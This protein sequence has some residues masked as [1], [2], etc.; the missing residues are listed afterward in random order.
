MR[1]PKY[2]KTALCRLAD[3]GF[4]ACLVGGCVR[5]FLMGIP[6][7]DFDITTSALP[8]QIC[9]IFAGYK[10]ATRGIIHGTVTVIFEGYP[11][12]ITSF[13][14]ESAYSDRR[15]PDSVLFGVSLKEDLMRRDFT[16]NAIAYRTQDGIYDP[17]GGAAD[18]KAKQ[19]RCVGSPKERFGEDALRIMRALRFA[20]RLCFTL[21]ADTAQAIHCK[22][23][24]LSTI[25]AERITDELCGILS[26]PK[27]GYLIH[28]YADVLAFVL[29]GTTAEEIKQTAGMLDDCTGYLPRLALIAHLCGGTEI[30]KR[31]TL[32]NTD[33]KTIAL[34]CR[35]LPLPLPSTRIQLCRLIRQTGFETIGTLLSLWA[36][37]GNDT[38]PCAL[39]YERILSDGDCCTLKQLAVTGADFADKTDGIH[40]GQILHGLLDAVIDELVPNERQALLD[41][42]EDTYSAL[43]L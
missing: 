39:L 36:A 17:F 29:E 31:L 6:P 2:V 11:C 10:I 43:L 5:D 27:V 42:A 14:A 37:M 4:E 23:P 8:E 35:Y 21:E 7:H 33:R 41:Y 20:A 19:I 25:A 16:I 18:I 15:H 28:E 38:A 12:E 32:R 22:Y 3:E 24:L 13:R 26:A 9:N 40:I 1:Y 34:L 30:Y